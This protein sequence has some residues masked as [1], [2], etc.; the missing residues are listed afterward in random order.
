MLSERLKEKNLFSDE[1]EATEAQKKVARKLISDCARSLVSAMRCVELDGAMTRD[2]IE[3]FTLRR[4]E[5]SEVSIYS[6]DKEE[7]DKWLNERFVKTVREIKR[8][9]I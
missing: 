9:M 4:I 8:S 5:Q 7:F 2:E 1:Q 3:N 6:L